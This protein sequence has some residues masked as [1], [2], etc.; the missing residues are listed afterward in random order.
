[1]AMASGILRI[2]TA[3]ALLAACSPAHHQSARADLP[4]ADGSAQSVAKAIDA[5]TTFPNELDPRIWDGTSMRPDVRQMTLTVVDR[6][7]KTSGIDG[8][9]VDAVELFGSNA[10]Y[11]YDDTSDFGVHVFARSASFPADKLDGLLEAAERRRG[12]APGGPH[13]LQRGAAGGDVPRR[14]HREDQPRPGIGQYSISQG[15]WIEMPVRQPDRF[16]R[17]QMDT[18]LKSFIAAYNDLVSACAANRKGFDCARFGDLDA[19]LCE[20]RNTLFVNGFGVRS[21][22]NLTYRAL[23]R[24]NVS[25]PDMVD[26]LEDECIFVNESVG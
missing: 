23:R 12:A 25:I 3:V 26:R 9:T 24:L 15:R 21:T 18:D 6:V 20:C 5:I 4:L 19:R 16:D 2:V 13:D 10:S 17:A 22:Q 7:V 14:A 11:E 8:L 1:M